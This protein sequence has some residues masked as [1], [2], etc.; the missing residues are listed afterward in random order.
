MSKI[1]VKNEP[2]VRDS[3]TGALLSTDLDAIRAYERK[4]QELKV[5]KERINRLEEEIDGL[6]KMVATLLETQKR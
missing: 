5:Q 1:P 4:K 6:K 3:R 2:L